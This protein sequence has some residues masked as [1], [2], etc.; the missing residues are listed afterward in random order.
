MRGNK[1]AGTRPEM[2]VRRL[3]HRLGYRYR[4]Q[5]S[6]LPGKPD[7]VFRRHKV[8]ILVNGCFW[9]QHDDPCCPLRAKPRSNT[10]YWD[11][12]LARNVQRDTETRAALEAL[13]WRLLIVWEC[14]TRDAKR[15]EARL[16]TELGATPGPCPRSRGI[17]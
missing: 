16:T 14:E 3:L 6:D 5:A 1:R 9:H 8:A 2:M 13:G 12:K 4:L 17:S 10:G 7:I 11:A 15:V